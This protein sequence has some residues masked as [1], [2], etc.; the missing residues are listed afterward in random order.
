M[1]AAEAPVAAQIFGLLA[2]VLCYVAIQ[3]PL[4]L[5][6]GFLLP[7]RFQRAHPPLGRYLAGLA[8]GVAVHATLLFSTAVAM[9]AAG[10]LGGI[11]GVVLAGAALMLLL[12]R[13]R[14]LLAS[15][16]APLEVTPSDERSTGAEESVATFV[17]ESQ[18]EGF[19][20][21]IVGVL[22]PRLHLL[23]MKWREMLEPDQLAAA[24]ERRT[25]AVGSGSWLRGRLLALGF[26]LTGIA[27][28][29][30]LVGRDRLGTAS[31]TVDLSLWFTLWSFLGLLLLPT[32]SRRG[33][34]EVDERVL[35]AGCS[36]STMERSIAAIDDLQDRERN[37]PPW[38]E[39]IFH[40][41]PS[42]TQRLRGPH[43]LGLHGF[44]DAARTSVFLS[45][46]G[47]GL[48]GRAVHCNCG[49]PSLWVFLP[50]D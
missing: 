40:P 15:A 35:E 30:C 12:L 10:R 38:V 24:L 48:L 27:V 16:A 2:F 7:R 14:V 47:L 44:W 6:G 50:G 28:A 19:T 41:V 20:G 3:L 29:A 17:A 49:R 45:A 9:F 1:P 21:G 8:R 37:R 22:V 43:S 32:P 36:R 46:A 5:C 39:T 31:G 42:V 25:M 23:P 13:G 4:D 33:V 26:T 11:V 34:T 18:D